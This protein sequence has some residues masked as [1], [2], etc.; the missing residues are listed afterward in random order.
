[1]YAMIRCMP[2][3]HP[4][5][6]AKG[7]LCCRADRGTLEANVYIGSLLIDLEDHTAD[8]ISLFETVIRLVHEVLK[9]IVQRLLVVKVFCLRE[10]KQTRFRWY[11][12]SDTECASAKG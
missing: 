2:C 12:H 5:D 3:S 6:F 9:N 10:W 4:S 8:N 7:G 11:A 1:M